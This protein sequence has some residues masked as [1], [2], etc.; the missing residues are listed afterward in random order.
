SVASLALSL[1]SLASAFRSLSVEPSLSARILC[2]PCNWPCSNAAN[3]DSPPAS[4][5][6][7]ALPVE[8]P[9]AAPLA[10]PE[11]VALPV[12]NVAVRVMPMLLVSLLIACLF[13]ACVRPR[14]KFVFLGLLPAPFP[15]FGRTA[16]FFHQHLENLGS[17]SGLFQGGQSIVQ[18]LPRALGLV[19]LLL[20]GP[21]QVG[22]ELLEV[23]QG[24]RGDAGAALA[25]EAVGV[26][27]PVALQQ[28]QLVLGA[29]ALAQQGGKAPERVLLARLGE[30]DQGLGGVA[31]HAAT[32]RRG[33]GPMTR[34]R[35]EK[36][37][38]SES[39]SDM[40]CCR[41]RSMAG[42]SSMASSSILSLPFT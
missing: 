4:P 33:A 36:L 38:S 17:P 7:P 35:P 23:L 40:S 21:L 5:S 22:H 20:H 2:D 29:A 14:C 37:L 41:K 27:A 10:A 12:F 19:L 26:L 8:E 3:G 24:E 15:D 16:P 42:C 18:C 28:R 25:G 32:A 9:P 34:A 31:S 1:P 11:P 39:R 13:I 6:P 30:V